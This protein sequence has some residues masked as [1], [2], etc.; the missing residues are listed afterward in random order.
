MER[1]KG[2]RE[3]GKKGGEGG[4]REEEGGGTD[5][6]GTKLISCNQNRREGGWEKERGSKGEKRRKGR[7]KGWGAP[8]YRYCIALNST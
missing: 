8:L 2:G 6:D 1:V 5:K 3:G 4:R 7:K